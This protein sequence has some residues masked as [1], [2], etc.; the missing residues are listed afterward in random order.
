MLDR[1]ELQ[2]VVQNNHTGVFQLNVHDIAC[3]QH[4]PL[5]AELLLKIQA[6]PPEHGLRIID[7]NEL[8]GGVV[9]FACGG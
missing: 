1:D 9:D 3:L 5:I 7:P 8:T 4:H 6:G 2:G